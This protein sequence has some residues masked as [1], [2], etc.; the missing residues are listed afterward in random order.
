LNLKLARSEKWQ[1]RHSKMM[2]FVGMNG[3]LRRVARVLK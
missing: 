1:M 3:W 2:R